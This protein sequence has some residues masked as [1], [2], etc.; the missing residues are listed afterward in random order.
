[1]RRIFR[2]FVV[3]TALA[4]MALPT[5]AQDLRILVPSSPGSGLTIDLARQLFP[6]ATLQP[7]T[8]RN[9]AANH[10][11]LMKQADVVLLAT[12]SVGEFELENSSIS[13]DYDQLRLVA[14]KPLVLWT[15]ARNLDRVRKFSNL[16]VAVP[17]DATGKEGKCGDLLRK[18]GK[19]VQVQKY[20]K[21]QS[22][23]SDLKSGHLVALCAPFTELSDSSLPLAFS[24]VAF[25][26][27]NGQR[28][29]S[30]P[31]VPKEVLDGVTE[32]IVV[33]IPKKSDNATRARALQAVERNI[34]E[35]RRDAEL[36]GWTLKR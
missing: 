7:N 4:A 18:Y 19:S 34:A 6:S 10:S 29:E 16:E 31:A 30:F 12:D 32:V 11:Q 26:A 27:T 28:I 1:M 23:V 15:T 20:R 9:F 2:I 21:I 24:S 36:S 35:Q 8:S 14:V 17:S 33:Y 22:A 25:E 5:A 13:N 3:L